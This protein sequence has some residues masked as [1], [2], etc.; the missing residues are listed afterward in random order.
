[1]HMRSLGASAGYPDWLGKNLL[2]HL[3]KHT[4]ARSMEVEEEEKVEEEAGLAKQ[5]R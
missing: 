3:H 5:K 2:L 4:H 1:M